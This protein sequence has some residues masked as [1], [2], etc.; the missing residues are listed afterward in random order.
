MQVISFGGK[1]PGGKQAAN[2]AKQ[3]TQKALHGKEGGLK[4]PLAHDTLNLSNKAGKAD[5]K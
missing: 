4:K 3:A 1:I 5:K 2:G